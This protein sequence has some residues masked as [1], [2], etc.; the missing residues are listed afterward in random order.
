MAEVLTILAIGSAILFFGIFAEFLFNKFRIPDVLLLIAFGF[1]LGPYVFSFAN[2]IYLNELAPIFTTFA[3]LFL[4]F[5]GA[6]NIDIVSFIKGLGKGI[7]ITGSN[8]IVSSAAITAISFLFGFGLLNSLLIGFILGGV[9]SAFVLPIIQNLK[10]K[11]E[12]Y[13]MLTLES[14]ITDV[15]CIVFALTTIEIISLN[16][17]SFNIAI[18]KIVALFAVAGF[19]G[20]I[21][22]LLWIVFINKVMKKNKSYMLTIASLLLLYTVTEY[23]H[24]NGAIATLFFGL[25]LKNSKKLTSIIEGDDAISVTTPTEQLFYSQISFFLKT[26]FFVYIGILL[27]FSSLKALSIGLLI[28]IAILFSR[29]ISSIFTKELPPYDKK[30][31]NSIFARGLAA[32]VLAQLAI[33]NGLQNA[34]LISKIVFSAIMFTIILSSAMV[35]MT[36]RSYKKIQAVPKAQAIK[37]GKAA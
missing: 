37:A 21:A 34:E 24:G 31:V 17:F 28:S 8:F 30:I 11:K 13:A 16:T 2:P 9:S 36:D 4:L 6:F 23:L 1:L 7:L 20:V 15:L 22:G 5:D 26:F 32:A 25:V 18:S 14:A 27:D 35:F 33:Q 29:K 12:T 10:I 3:L 19:F